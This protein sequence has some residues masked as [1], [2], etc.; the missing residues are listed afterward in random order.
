[1]K[2]HALDAI[3]LAL[4]GARVLED[5]D[6][7]TVGLSSYELLAASHSLVT[8]YS[9]IWTDYLSTGKHVAFAVADWEDYRATRGLDESVERSSL[10]GPVVAS[11]EDVRGLLPGS[12][13]R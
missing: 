12:R 8:D 13:G 11:A 7:A 10:P 9:S 4:P 2:P 6:L 5:A 3:A 1:M